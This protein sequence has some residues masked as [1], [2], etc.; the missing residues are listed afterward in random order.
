MGILRRL[1]L[2]SLAI[3][4][5]I[6]TCC[7]T[8]FYAFNSWDL[9]VPRNHLLGLGNGLKNGGGLILGGG[10]VL[11]ILRYLHFHSSSRN[12][13]NLANVLCFPAKANREAEQYAAS[14]KRRQLLGS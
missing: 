8:I 6:G 7:H 11:Q 10:L 5:Y 12:N 14:Q 4:S 1:A 2:A 13:V 3:C 9:L